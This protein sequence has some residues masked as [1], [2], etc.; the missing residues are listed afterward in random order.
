MKNLENPT[1]RQIIKMS[2]KDMDAH[3]EK[4]K[5]GLIESYIKSNYKMNENIK[6]LLKL[7]KEWFDGMPQLEG[8]FFM[9]AT[10]ELNKLK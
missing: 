3:T 9:E 1:S 8:N 6:H 5:K 7:I 2:Q 4:L 10:N